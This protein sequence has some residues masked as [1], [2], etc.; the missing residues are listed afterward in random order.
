MIRYIISGFAG[1][2][3]VLTLLKRKENLL[4]YITH[5]NRAKRQISSVQNMVVK[6]KKYAAVLQL[7]MTYENMFI[8]AV[9]A[10]HHIK[11]ISQDN[12]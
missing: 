11:I 5:E 4:L 9:Q 2:C 8:K 7:K 10:F 3:S 12:I 6:T 1:L